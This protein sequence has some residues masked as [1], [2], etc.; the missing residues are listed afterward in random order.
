MPRQAEHPASAAAL[1]HPGPRASACRAC[2]AVS[3]APGGCRHWA[4]WYRGGS[5]CLPIPP[6]GAAVECRASRRVQVQAHQDG[7]ACPAVGSAKDDP[8][9]EPGGCRP[10]RS[11]DGQRVEAYCRRRLQ[12]GW[13]PVR[14]AVRALPQVVAAAPRGVPVWRHWG[15][16]VSEQGE[17]RQ[18]LSTR[19][20]ERGGRGPERR[21]E[22][23]HQ[24]VWLLPDG[25]AVRPERQGV[26]GA[27]RVW[28]LAEPGL[29]AGER[30]QRVWPQRVRALQGGPVP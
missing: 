6:G 26:R 9:E 25:P 1:A 28:P 13:A 24:P 20:P 7:W 15:V 12:A 30:E 22:L 17:H 8:T 23:V 2:Q 10:D 27:R 29:P 18:V 5:A 4:R 19:S 21:G 11:W 14:R 16:L 3:A